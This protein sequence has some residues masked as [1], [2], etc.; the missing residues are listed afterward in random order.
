MSAPSI[1]A[2]M[3]AR[4]QPTPLEVA[5]ALVRE[6]YGVAAR[7]ERLTGERDENFKLTTG[8]G[9][10]YVLKIAHADQPP[11]EADLAVSVLEWIARAD[12]SMPCPRVVRARVG[13]PQLRLVVQ[14]V[15]RSVQLLTYLRGKPLGLTAR[16]GAQ[17]AA[18]GALAGRL[19]LA[20]QGF[21]HPA[22]R[23]AL[24]WDVQQIT[25]VASLLQG[26]RE[27]P[28][29]ELAGEV[30]AEI[31]P[32][33]GAELPAVRHQVVHNDLNPFNVLVDAA[34]PARIRGVIDFGDVAHTAVVADVAVTAA[35]QIP[36]DCAEDECMRQAIQDVVGAYTVCL[37]LQ[38]QELSLLEMLI[39]ARL[40]TSLVVQQWHLE[41]NPAGGHYAALDSSFIQR[42]LKMAR[43]LI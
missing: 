20:L 22:A 1:M 40:I 11:E 42:R 19:T 27:F 28:G 9:A 3:I 38:P 43:G 36:E 15:E 4:P 25:E 5:A 26:L 6:H 33:V 24:I 16:S 35:E 32:V 37:P 17:R 18:C 8:D 10:E 2:T 41:H 39:A 7:A 34:E 23:R 29:R 12:A 13:L 14:G 21:E 30:L 31:V